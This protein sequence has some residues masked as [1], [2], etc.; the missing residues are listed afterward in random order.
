MALLAEANPPN[1]WHDTA[2]EWIGPAPDTKRTI[3]TDDTREILS[4]NDSPD[5]GFTWSVNPYRGCMHG[6][7]YCYAR[8]SHEF[9][10]FGAGTDFERRIVVKPKAAVLL[11]KAF[12]RTRWQGEVVVFSGNTDCYQ[13]IEASYRLTRACLQ[14]CHRYRN[15]VGIITKSPLVERDIDVLADLARVTYVAVTLSI[16]FFDPHHA[17]LIEPTVPPPARRFEAIRR[18]AA[19]GIPVGVNVAPIIPGL[20]DTQV[21][22]ILE[23]AREAGARWA[24]YTSVRLPGP[25]ANIFTEHIERVFSPSKANRILS[26]IRDGRGGALNKSQFHDRFR[27]EGPYAAALKALFES[28]RARLGFEGPP[29]RP[30]PS[31]FRRPMPGASGAQLALFG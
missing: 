31:P 13:P 18:L 22:D 28:T 21:V 10:G 4:R 5:I 27:T 24:G 12:E 3:Y 29:P 9:L 20:S 30:D 15:P 11:E 8:P 19:A 16:P 6:C 7:V 23:A 26:R 25:V 17:R 1:P 14:V 2:V